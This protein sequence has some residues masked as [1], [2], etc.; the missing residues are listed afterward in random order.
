MDQEFDVC[1]CGAGPTGATTGYYLARLSDKY[2][3]NLKICLL[4]KAK[5]PRDKFCGDAWCAPALDILEDMGVLQELERRGVVNETVVGGFV[6]PS[7][8]SFIANDTG[9]PANEKNM[10]TR[11]YAIKRLICDEAIAMK[12]KEAGC[13]LKEN[14]L[15]EDAVL[16]ESDGV[17]TV[18]I[19]SGQ[20]LKCKIL[21]AAD[22]AASNL[23]RRL[24]I[25]TT[26]PD[27]V[28]ARQYIKG[29]THNFKA[30][31]VLLYPE[32]TLPGKRL[33]ITSEMQKHNQHT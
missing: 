24:G 19:A 13:I 2:N 26:P 29:G 3:L 11:A 20:K 32:Y 7:G 1:I 10:S 6:S 17:W 18:S 16:N 12:A 21:I 31:G 25:V 23:A 8:H 4:D 15:V 28:A 5:F 9:V 22:G 14:H 27:G 33:S 30:D